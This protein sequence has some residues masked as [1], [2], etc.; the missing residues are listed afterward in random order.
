M[1]AGDDAAHGQ[2]PAKEVAKSRV[3]TAFGVGLIEVHHDIHMDIAVTS[4]TEAGHGESMLLLEALG[5]T[6]QLFQ[7]ATRNSDVLVQ[8]SETRVAQG[9]REFAA[10]PPERLAFARFVGALNEE[11]PEPVHQPGD[12]DEFMADGRLL[13]VE[14]NDEMG[15]AALESFAAGALVRGSDGK[16]IGYFEC[17]G[18]V[19][20]LEN[21]IDRARGVPHGPKTD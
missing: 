19:P 16:S 2:D 17:G 21:G 3:T 1:F 11:R 18:Q 12:S 14:F 7:L 5:E 10:Q 20:I 9:V 6:E 15:L 13:T 8:L 4:M